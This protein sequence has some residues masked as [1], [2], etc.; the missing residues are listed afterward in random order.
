MAIEAVVNDDTVRRQSRRATESQRDPR[1]PEENETEINGCPRYEIYCKTVGV[2]T[3]WVVFLT[4]GRNIILRRRRK[5]N[6]R[7]RSENDVALRQMM[8]CFA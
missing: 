8:L 6:F 1:H 4:E 7:L 5:Y 2:S 3:H